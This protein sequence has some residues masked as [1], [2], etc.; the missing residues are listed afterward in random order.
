M[1]WDALTY[2]HRFDA[3]PTEKARALDAKPLTRSSPN[4]PRSAKV[5]ERRLIWIASYVA[6]NLSAS[7]QPFL[8]NRQSA[9]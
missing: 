1:R 5:A 7:R 4:A 6:H 3:I 8:D 9:H 2:Y